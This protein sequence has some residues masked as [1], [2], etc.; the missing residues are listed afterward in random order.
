MFGLKNIGESLLFML[1]HFDGTITILILIF[2]LSGALTILT[3]KQTILTFCTMYLDLRWNRGRIWCRPGPST[4]RGIQIVLTK[5][6]GPSLHQILPRRPSLHQ[7]LPRFQSRSLSATWQPQLWEWSITYSKQQ[8]G[9]MIHFSI[10]PSLYT[11]Y[12]PHS[13]CTGWRTN[14]I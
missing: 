14:G 7:I 2:L 12:F 5:Y 4:F 11:A 8:V 13:L 10:F 1:R 3:G 6:F 9:C